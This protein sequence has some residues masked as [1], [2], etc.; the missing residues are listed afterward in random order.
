MGCRKTAALLLMKR[1]LRND[2]ILIAA[3]LLIAAAVWGVFRLAR[4]TGDSVSVTVDGK[5]FGRY[6]LHEDAEI[7][8]PSADGHFNKLVISNGSARIESADC[9]DKLCVK[10]GFV[11][12]AGQT[13]IC[14]PHRV[15][16]TIEGT[17][18]VDAP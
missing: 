13:V 1:K 6:S 11:K 14:L 9:P 17:G 15:V 10:R 16:V 4:R 18:E 12:N 5:L 8:I 3:L 7:T 2:V